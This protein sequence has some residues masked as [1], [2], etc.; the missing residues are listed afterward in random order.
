MSAALVVSVVCDAPSCD[1]ERVATRGQNL[2]LLLHESCWVR[3]GS[4]HFCD[5]HGRDALAGR[6]FGTYPPDV[7]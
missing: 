6:P 4:E 3:V 5:D 7:F 2:T 1:R